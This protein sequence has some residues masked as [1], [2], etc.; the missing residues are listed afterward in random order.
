MTSTTSLLSREK[1]EIYV[2]QICSW[3]NYKILPNIRAKYIRVLR[4]NGS[5]LKY[6]RKRFN[7]KLKLKLE[8]LWMKNRRRKN[9]TL[10]N[11]LRVKAREKRREEMTKKGIIMVGI[12]SSSQ[13]NVNL[14][15]KT[16]ND[17]Y[18]Y[19]WIRFWL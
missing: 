17:K 12:A 16:E 8:S 19:Y 13:T 15:K 2:R 10:K 7:K 18:F 3:R 5:W 1:K 6:R 14:L 9:P 4:N 11:S